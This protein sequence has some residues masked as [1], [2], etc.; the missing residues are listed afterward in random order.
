MSSPEDL[1]R[2]L[3][4]LYRQLRDEMWQKW[5]RHVSLG[6]LVTDRWETARAYG[7]GE[8]ASC[9]DNVLVKG[10]V[11]VGRETWIGPNCIL[12]GVG[13]LSLGDYC[14]ISA[15]VHIYTHDTVKWSTSLGKDP[16]DRAPVVIGSG[17]YIGPQTVVQ[18]GVTIGD[19]AVIGAMSLVNK[20]IPPGARAWGVPA[21]IVDQPIEQ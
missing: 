1:F 3:Q 14:A 21:R 5:K 17:V 20:D 13:G 15:G 11:S 19:G 10:D 6:D 2:D 18:K 7:F 9:Y 12:D 4:I 8:G 16:E